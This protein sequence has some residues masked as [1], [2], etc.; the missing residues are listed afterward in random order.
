MYEDNNNYKCI[1][2]KKN[3]KEGWKENLKFEIILNDDTF[4]IIDIESSK[5][6]VKIFKIS[7]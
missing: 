6:Y 4:K 2:I 5:D 1:L 3:K 7:I